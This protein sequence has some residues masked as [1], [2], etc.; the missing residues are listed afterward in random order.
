MNIPNHESSPIKTIGFKKSF[1]LRRSYQ[2][3]I[4]AQFF[5]I[6]VKIVHFSFLRFHKYLKLLEIMP[7]CKDKTLFIKG[8]GDT[9][10]F[11]HSEIMRCCDKN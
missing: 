8:F 2:K 9:R 1:M 10:F 5:S 11:T 3:L 4:L 6:R 7:A